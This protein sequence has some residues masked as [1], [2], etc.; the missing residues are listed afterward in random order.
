M[1]NKIVVV[2]G[3]LVVLTVIVL[4]VVKKNNNNNDNLTRPMMM[5]PM[6][7]AGYMSNSRNQRAMKSLNRAKEGFLDTY[8]T[9]VPDSQNLQFSPAPYK[10]PFV[11]QLDDSVNTPSSN[12]DM[13]EDISND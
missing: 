6:M 1:A 9:N 3:I 2:M 7:S 10:S 8:M 13:I 4:L 12:W 11:G 5:N